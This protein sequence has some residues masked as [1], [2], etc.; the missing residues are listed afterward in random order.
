MTRH[1]QQATAYSETLGP[2]NRIE[3][4]QINPGAFEMG[5]QPNEPYYEP[6]E[7]PSHTVRVSGLF[8]SRFEITQQQWEAVARLP[9]IAVDL[10]PQ[11][12]AFPGPDRPVESVTWVEAKEFCARLSASKGRLYRLPTE[13]EWEFACRAGTQTPFCFGETINSALANYQATKPYAQEGRGEYRRETIP[14]GSLDAANYFGLF[15]VHGNVSEWC[16]D[17]FG[18]YP[19]AFIVNPTGPKKGN[20]RVVRGGSWRS[21]PWQCRSASRVGFHKD[22]RRNDIG[23]RIVLPRIVMVPAQGG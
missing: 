12:S 19:N 1:P 10:P 23:F 6:V 3:M 8:I 11:P 21:Y 18:E 7:G 4:I 13:A 16:E 2:G 14:V 17:R 20:D 9:K 15:D 5:S 22:Y